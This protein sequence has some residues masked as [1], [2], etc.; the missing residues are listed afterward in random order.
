M[1]LYL[2]KTQLAW[3][4][5]ALQRSIGTSRDIKIAKDLIEEMRNKEIEMESLCEL[6][7]K[8]DKLATSL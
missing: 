4:L 7:D 2:N 6:V 1:I 5:A 8:L 3:I